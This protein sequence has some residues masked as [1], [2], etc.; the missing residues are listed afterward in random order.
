MFTKICGD[1]ILFPGNDI[2]GIERHSAGLG[3][4]LRLG[5]L[6][7]FLRLL[8]QLHDLGREEARLQFVVPAVLQLSEW[9]GVKRSALYP[10]SHAMLA[11][12]IENTCLLGSEIGKF[13]LDQ[14]GPVVAEI[15][16]RDAEN[17]IDDLL[18]HLF[19]ECDT[20]RCSPFALTGRF[21]R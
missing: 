20:S 19:G 1:S 5:R 15:D 16:I 13:V 14:F 6:P 11:G 21:S 9:V 17:V 10:N 2:N 8:A 3:S 12:T 7:S 4:I 18:I